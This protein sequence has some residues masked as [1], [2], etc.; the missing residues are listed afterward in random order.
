MSKKGLLWLGI[1][2]LFVVIIALVIY[3]DW[4]GNVKLQETA[5]D[6]LKGTVGAFL[7]AWANELT[8]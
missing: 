4:Y 7:G 5:S 2:L 8:K 1:C 6:L 3:S